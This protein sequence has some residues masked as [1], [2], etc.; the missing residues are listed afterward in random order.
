MIL[1]YT[2]RKTG[3]KVTG[4]WKKYPLNLRRLNAALFLLL[5]VLM[6][7]RKYPSARFVSRIR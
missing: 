3:E 7:P 6:P 4:K 2:D 5:F 1:I